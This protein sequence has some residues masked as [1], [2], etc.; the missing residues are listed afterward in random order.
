MIRFIYGNIK[1]NDYAIIEKKPNPEDAEFIGPIGRELLNFYDF[2]KYS[3]KL[4][5]EVGY[6]KYARMIRLQGVF[7]NADSAIYDYLYYLL[8]N[9]SGEERSQVISAGI[10]SCYKTLFDDEPNYHIELEEVKIVKKQLLNK[11]AGK[12]VRV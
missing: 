1:F 5:S 8:I 2:E 11:N 12:K 9:T 4:I 6:E 7:K 3:K 10:E